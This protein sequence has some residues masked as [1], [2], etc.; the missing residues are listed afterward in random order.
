M[1]GNNVVQD[2]SWEFLE[3]EEHVVFCFLS[4]YLCLWRK[5]EVVGRIP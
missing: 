5:I 2:D 1:Y 4:I 3:S